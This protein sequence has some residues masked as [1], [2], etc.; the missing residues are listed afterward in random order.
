MQID[1]EIVSYRGLITGAINPGFSGCIRGMYGTSPASHERGA[2]V[3]HLAERRNH[4][5]IDPE[6]E[7]QRNVNGRIAEIVRETGCEIALLDG[8]EFLEAVEPVW[9]HENH[10]FDDLCSRFPGE[11]R[12]YSNVVPHFGWHYVSRLCAAKRN[13][14]DWRESIARTLATTVK[15]SGDNFMATEIGGLALYSRPATTSHSMKRD[16][17]YAGMTSIGFDIPCSYIL[18]ENHG[19]GKGNLLRLLNLAGIYNRLRNEAFFTETVKNEI[20]KDTGAFEL[21][22]DTRTGWDAV[23][24]KRHEYRFSLKSREKVSWQFDNEYSGQPL[25]FRLTALPAAEDYSSPENLLLAD[26][27]PAGNFRTITSS[28][29]ISS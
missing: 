23:R 28:D 7:L 13:Y 4:Y 2:E 19:I 21:S 8:S 10:V 12:I 11:L 27:Q 17:H 18:P 6:S 24:I 3:R 25:S 15:T 26:F 16:V 5:I 14:T 20:R 29:A 9:Y 22:H 1:G